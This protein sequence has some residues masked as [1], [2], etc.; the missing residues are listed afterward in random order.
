MYCFNLA[1]LGK[2]GWKLMVEPNSSVSKILKEKYFP[3]L[4]EF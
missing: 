3:G 4:L 1:L 2:L